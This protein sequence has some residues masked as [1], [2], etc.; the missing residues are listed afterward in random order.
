MS[1]AEKN[2]IF[3]PDYNAHF[4][5]T[6]QKRETAQGPKFETSFTHNST[7]GEKGAIYV[8]N[9]LG[10]FLPPNLNKSPYAFFAYLPRHSFPEQEL[11]A[12]FYSEWMTRSKKL[13]LH[14]GSRL[15][16]ITL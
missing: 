14:L 16:M 15:I 4:S 7:A 9:S 3:M 2:V 6:R 11:K 13:T 10:M 1:F 8:E 5:I 12:V